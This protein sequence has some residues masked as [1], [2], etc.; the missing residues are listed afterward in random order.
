MPTRLCQSL[1]LLALFVICSAAGV[2]A[3]TQPDRFPWL[4]CFDC[5]TAMRCTRTW[6]GA[7]SCIVQ[8]TPST[9]VCALVDE[10]LFGQEVLF[11]RHFTFTQGPDDPL[12]PRPKL[13]PPSAAVV[14]LQGQVAAYFSKQVAPKLAACWPSYEKPTTLWFTH[15]YRQTQDG[16]WVHS[17]TD[18]PS[19]EAPHEV[20]DAAKKC[21]TQAERDS[22]FSLSGHTTPSPVLTV[23]WPWGVNARE[24]LER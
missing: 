23:V 2:R 17:Q 3:Q 4:G 21:M 5:A 16:R 20:V 22:G 14:A 1:P 13:N 7:R 11:P 10:C 24:Q 9:C 6:M 18:I 8:C 19:S 12:N 15:S